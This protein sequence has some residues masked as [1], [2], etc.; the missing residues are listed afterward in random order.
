MDRV[1]RWMERNEVEKDSRILDLGCGN[2]VACL[3]MT[4]EDFTDVTGVDYR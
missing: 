1:F 4:C 2:G 3:E